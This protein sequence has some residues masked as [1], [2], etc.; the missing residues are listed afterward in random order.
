MVS[1]MDLTHRVLLEG[2]YVYVVSFDVAGAFDK[3]PHRML[4]KALSKMGVDG[5]TRRLRREAP[6]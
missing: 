3:V 6:D 2:C 5:R 4:T 1:V